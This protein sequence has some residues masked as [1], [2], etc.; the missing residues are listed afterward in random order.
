MSFT[1]AYI[2]GLLGGLIAELLYWTH[3]QKTFHKKKPE[4]FSSRFYWI[5]AIIW[6]IIGGFV[7]WIYLKMEVNVNFLICMHLGATAPVTL[8]QITKGQL[9]VK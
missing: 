2:Y 6:I 1:E 3:F 9:D 7:P 5:C 4:L 8:S